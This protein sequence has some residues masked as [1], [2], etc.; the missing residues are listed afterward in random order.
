METNDLDII[1]NQGTTFRQRITITS[2]GVPT[3]LDD[4]TFRGKIT[5]RPGGV[6]ICSLQITKLEQNQYPG[7]VEIFIPASITQ[8]VPV[9]PSPAGMRRLTPYTLDIEA[10]YNA[11]GDVEVAAKG[12]A[13]ISPR[14]A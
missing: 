7:G 4:R 1:I 2:G 5:A 14:A 3:N 11:T 10:I 8:R 9:N 6:L 12:T 13:F